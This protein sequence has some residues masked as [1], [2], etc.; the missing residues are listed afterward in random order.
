[1]TDAL[2]K[3][4]VNQS[5]APV[6]I[7][8]NYER[9]EAAPIR[10]VIWLSVIFWASSSAVLA[11]GD[12]SLAPDRLPEVIGMRMTLTAL[13]LLF[14][15]VIHL[16]LR[17]LR[18]RSFRY[19]IIALVLVTPIFA[20]IFAWASYF[21][22]QAAFGKPLEIPLV[23]LAGVLGAVMQFTWLFLAWAGFYFALYY[24]AEAEAKERRTAAFRA[25]AQDAQFQALAYQINPHFLFNSLNA[26]SA[27]MVDGRLRD[28][29]N[30]VTGLSRFLRH[31]LATDP[32]SLVTLGEEVA[33][34]REYLAIEQQRFPD[35][36]IAYDIPDALSHAY[37]PALSLQPLV[38]NA[39]K[40]GVARSAS[41]TRIAI[42]AVAEK[43]TL[44]VV[45][46]NCGGAPTEGDRDAR[47]SGLGLRNVRDRL[48]H[49]YGNAAKLDT[50]VLANA[51]FRATIS[52]PLS[53]SL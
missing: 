37:L 41:P 53:Y 43:Q 18:H 27:L 9:G 46:E 19:R 24:A 48:S 26:V 2:W 7:D 34:Q 49:I 35:L 25:M 6:I 50:T 1:M 52:L 32:T 10:G 42:T 28:A 20:E 40:H 22:M 23:N 39:V 47:R 4:F 38:E 11:I 31:T 16:L 15:F 36:E 29:E 30:V 33:I 12:V 45:V 21:G 3:R 5:I 17:R 51:G 8:E 44:Q 13:G 14:C